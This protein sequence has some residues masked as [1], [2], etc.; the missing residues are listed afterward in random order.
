[1]QVT[2]QLFAMA[3]QRAGAPRIVV[4]VPEP[5]TVRA[6]RTALARAAPDLAQLMP[7]IRFAVNAEYA[8]DDQAIP[9]GAEVAA[10]P[11]VSGGSDRLEPDT[12]PER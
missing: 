2:V 8:D 12:R 10:I 5:A 11:P 4:D 9:P 3:R 1:M 7:S 6:L